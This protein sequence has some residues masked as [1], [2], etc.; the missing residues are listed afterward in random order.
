VYGPASTSSNAA[1]DQCS[2]WLDECINTH[3]K[4]KG[5]TAKGMPKRIIDIGWSESRADVVISRFNY[6]AV[7]LTK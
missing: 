2:V 3:C 7:G 6:F 4:C 1:L 5:P